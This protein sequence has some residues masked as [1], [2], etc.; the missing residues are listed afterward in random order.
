MRNTATV[1]TMSEQ[2]YLHSEA[3]A[4]LKHEFVQGHIFAMSG[5][6]AA[7]NIISG[8][9]FAALHSK[10][11]GTPCQIYMH[12]MKV[13]IEAAQSYYYPDIMV[14]CE[15]FEGK[16]V[17]MSRP[18]LLIEVLSPGTVQIDRR[19]KLV[20]YQKLASLKEY[21]L[22]HQDRQRFELYQRQNDTDWEVK[23]GAPG[24][25][26]VLTSL[27][28]ETV[29]LPMSSIYENCTPPGRI[30]EKEEDYFFD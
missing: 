8:N 28:C 4:K 19:E 26:L 2:E 6:T 3:Q 23:V 9:L 11:R 27:Q 15:A 16:S 7:H 14:T 20:A 12:D 1:K 30:K 24:D 17:F 21:L 5:S 22:V 29:V 25:D 13:R 10:L 18:L